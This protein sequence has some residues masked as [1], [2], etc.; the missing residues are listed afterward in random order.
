MKRWTLCLALLAFAALP[1]LA[2]E[3][4]LTD[5]AKAL[6]KAKTE[7]KPLVMDFTGSDWCGWCIKLDKEVFGKPEFKSY[8]AKN[9]VLLKLDF[10]RRRTLPAAEKE[11]NEALAGKYGIRGF[12]TIVVLDPQGETLG[13]LG[14]QP[15]GPKPWIA[16]LEKLTQK[17]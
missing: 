4:W 6:E 11:Q 2:A 7:N 9:L 10:P 5:H 15:G 17:P 13:Q 8:A 1:L 3:G 16:E 12:P 14:Y